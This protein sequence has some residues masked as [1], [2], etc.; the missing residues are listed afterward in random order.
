MQSVRL[1]TLLAMKLKQSTRLLSAV[2]GHSTDCGHVFAVKGDMRTF[3]EATST[4]D[5][6]DGCSF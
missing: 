5:L 6:C 4:T 3:S 2:L 1:R